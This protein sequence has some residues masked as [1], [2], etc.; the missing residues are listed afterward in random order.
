ML[1]GEWLR[2]WIN[3]EF[4]YSLLVIFFFLMIRRPPRSTLFP[5]T[6][7]F[8]SRRD[9]ATRRRRDFCPLSISA[10]YRS[11][12]HTSELQ[13][14]DHLVCRLLLEKKKKKDHRRPLEKKKKT[15][16]STHQL[17]KLA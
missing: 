2:E 3:A 16:P 9:N 6:T 15:Q 11:E 12:E 7:L 4:D 14:P 13:S 17:S 10:V 8:R 5:Y 1:L